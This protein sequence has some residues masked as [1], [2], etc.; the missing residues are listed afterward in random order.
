ML[1]NFRWFKPSA[2]IRRVVL[3]L[4]WRDIYAK[5]A[6]WQSSSKPFSPTIKLTWFCVCSVYFMY[7]L[8]WLFPKRHHGCH[9]K[10]VLNFRKNKKRSKSLSLPINVKTYIFSFLN[11]DAIRVALINWSI[12]RPATRSWVICDKKLS[13]FY[14]IPTLTTLV[15]LLFR[16]ALVKHT[17]Y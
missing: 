1:C 8:R 13:I 12:Y 11:D 5:I 16:Q 9:M 3:S 17:F 7:C 6:T 14:V 2:V 15:L 4:I 10:F